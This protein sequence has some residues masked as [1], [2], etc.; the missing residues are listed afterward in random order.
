MLG[1]WSGYAP[2]MF[3]REKK[4]KIRYFEN[5]NKKQT[6]FGKTYRIW[7]DI[8]TNIFWLFIYC[9]NGCQN[10]TTLMA[11][12]C[13][14]DRGEKFNDGVN[15][16]QPSTK[17]QLFKKLHFVCKKG[18]WRESN[19]EGVETYFNFWSGFFLR[20]WNRARKTFRVPLCSQPFCI[21]V[22]VLP[23]SDWKKLVLPS[24]IWNI[25]IMAFNV[26]WKLTSESPV[27]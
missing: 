3:D 27:F 24:S 25:N 7:G 2:I 19:F 15:W 5:K 9:E 21:C 8:G 16:S 17:I 6:N 22:V 26:G 18:K 14:H 10:L 20:T 1:E 4:Y 13:Y 11:R 23:F 12:Y